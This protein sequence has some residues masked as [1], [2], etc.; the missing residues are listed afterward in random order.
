[1][2]T[3]PERPSSRERLLDATVTL[4]RVKGPTGSGTK[5]I[6][7]AAAAPR[8]SFYFHF[9]EGKDQLVLESLE[10]ASAATAKSLD[11]AFVNDTQDLR[12]QIKAYFAAIAA[13]LVAS[14]YRL[15]CAVGATTLE[16][17]STT[18]TFQLATASAFLSWTSTLTTRLRARGL[19]PE[20]A[21][22]T[23]DAL[24]SAMEGA[25][26]LARARRDPA[27]LAHA[28]DVLALSIEAAS[29]GQES[30]ID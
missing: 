4:M 7:D 16:T 15:G 29:T 10:R 12:A 2:N 5:Q 19:T 22:A 14:D 27:P 9:P 23:A 13:D 28:A 8:G 21:A 11:E 6:L 20:R 30:C 24:V 18:P 25:T 17:A 3:R 1:V 26:M